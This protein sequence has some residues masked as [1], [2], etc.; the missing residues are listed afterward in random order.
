M[1][2]LRHYKGNSG[3]HEILKAVLYFALNLT[4]RILHATQSPVNPTI[5]FIEGRRH[6]IL[7]KDPFQEVIAFRQLGCFDDML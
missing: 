6:R 3:K 1:F 4:G 2:K 5:R 7:H